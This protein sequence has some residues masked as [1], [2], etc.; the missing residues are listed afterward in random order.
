MYTIFRGVLAMQKACG[1]NKMIKRDTGEEKD[2]WYN[3]IHE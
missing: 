1:F 2:K 3:V